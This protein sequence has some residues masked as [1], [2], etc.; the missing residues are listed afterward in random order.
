MQVW[1]RVVEHYL[2]R[3][4][5]VVDLTYRSGWMWSGF[6]MARVRVIALDL[7]QDVG[8]VDA[9]ADCRYPPLRPLIADAVV[10]DP[11]WAED[12]GRTGY[13]GPKYNCSFTCPEQVL[14]LVR[15]EAWA[16]I[17]RPDGFLFVRCADYHHEGRFVDLS[18]DL[19]MALRPAWK[20]WDKV[21]HVIGGRPPRYPMV[22]PP[23]TRKVHSYFL[24]FR[25]QG[26]A[27]AGGPD[28]DA[29]GVAAARSGDHST[30][31]IDLF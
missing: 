18:M 25:R 28:R 13:A 9:I 23:K 4:A 14:D 2:P 7:D 8:G 5:V 24:V 31:E 27:Q 15:P 17:T 16:R 12:A 22:S 10:F 19:S 30:R 29:G 1:G 26:I 20:P 11:P 21:I 6:R 3:D